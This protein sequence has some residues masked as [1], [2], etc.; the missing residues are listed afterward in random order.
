M[1]ANPEENSLSINVIQ[2]MTEKGRSQALW[3]SF[4][5]SVSLD[6]SMPFF[7]DLLTGTTFSSHIIT[8]AL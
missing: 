6:N 7:V 4:R 1:I 2:V 8:L 5:R 3:V